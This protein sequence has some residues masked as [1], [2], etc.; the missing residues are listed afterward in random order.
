[1][2]PEDQADLEALER[3]RLDRVGYLAGHALAGILANP[4]LSADMEFGRIVKLA[5][6]Y[7]VA[8]E[9]RVEDPPVEH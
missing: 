2:I 3:A 4:T 1:M 9:K 6:D 5:A 7:A 8:L